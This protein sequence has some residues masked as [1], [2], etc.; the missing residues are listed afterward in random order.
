MSLRPGVHQSNWKLQLNSTHVHSTGNEQHMCRHVVQYIPRKHNTTTTGGKLGN[1]TQKQLNMSVSCELSSCPVVQLSIENK[2][3]EE[4]NIV[5]FQL[6]EQEPCLYNKY[7][8]NYS[9]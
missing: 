8:P 5:F 3:L 6:T 1:S 9:R 4:I 7:S 2:Y